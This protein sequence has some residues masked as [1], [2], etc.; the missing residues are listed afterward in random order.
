[1]V[2][3]VTLRF[4][5]KSRLPESPLCSV[6]GSPFM[7]SPWHMYM[8]GMHG[9]VSHTSRNCTLQ[10]EP[11]ILSNICKSPNHA[12]TDRFGF[13][14]WVLNQ[15]HTQHTLVTVLARSHFLYPQ[16]ISFLSNF[17]GL[18]GIFRLTSSPG[19][20]CTRPPRDTMS[21]GDAPGN[22]ETSCKCTHDRFNNL[23]SSN[24]SA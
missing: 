8:C 5:C 12:A 14:S 13:Y 19:F 10:P 15:V 23:L 1:M 11:E 16:A 20:S 7:S 4:F 2:F 9:T 6:D 17:K 18:V 21:A 24:R 22:T 3:S